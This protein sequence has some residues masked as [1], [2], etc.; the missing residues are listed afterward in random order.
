MAF[1]DEVARDPPVGQ[2]GEALLVLLQALDPRQLARGPELA[3]TDAVVAGEDERRVRVAALDPRELAL[4]VCLVAGMKLGI[5]VEPDAPAAAEDAVVRL[6][7][8]CER[9]P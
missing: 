7:E 5:L 4:T 1:P 6:D 2:I 3:P 8:R 9:V